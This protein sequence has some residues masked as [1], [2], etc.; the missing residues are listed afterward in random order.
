MKM[1]IVIPTIK[2]EKLKH[3][4]LN[5]VLKGRGLVYMSFSMVVGV[6]VSSYLVK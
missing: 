2:L 5:I 1:F 6:P 4:L 3:S